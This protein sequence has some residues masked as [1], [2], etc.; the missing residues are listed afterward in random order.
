MHSSPVQL[1]LGTSCSIPSGKM[2]KGFRLEVMALTCGGASVNRCLFKLHQK[3]KE[4]VHKVVNPF[5]TER[6]GYFFLDPPHLLKTVRNAWHNMKRR[7]A[8]GE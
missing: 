4:L 2:L 8:M 3:G 5:A 1:L 7:T 6:F